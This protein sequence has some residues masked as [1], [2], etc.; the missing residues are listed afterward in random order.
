M[1]YAIYVYATILSM[2]SLFAWL[3][4]S[5]TRAFRRG[6]TQI[7]REA[8]WLHGFLVLL[9]L[10]ILVQLTFLF[11]SGMQA[12]LSLLRQST[13]LRLTIQPGATDASVQGMIQ[14]LQQQSYIDTVLFITKEQALERQRKRDPELIE[15]LG[16]FGLQNPFPDTLGIRLKS[17]DA[18]PALK[19][20][21]RKPVYTAVVDPAF[22]SEATNQEQ[23]LERITEAVSGSR[24]LLLFI[25]GVMSLVLF[26][27]IV[28]LVT[29]RAG[30]RSQ[31]LFVERLM[32]GSRMHLGLPFLFEIGALLLMALLCSL[33]FITLLALLLPVVIPVL[34]SGGLFASWGEALGATF[35]SSL[36]LMIGV[37]LLL[38]ALLATVGTFLA[39]RI[40]TTEAPTP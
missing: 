4:S 19:E 24:I 10:L 39:L 11:G 27:T 30:S 16:T 36:P 8:G 26:S 35:F 33:V 6:L 1:K 15:F 2:P 13:D 29:R 3:P 21:L 20:L 25:A 14:E 38:L 17:L 12:G 18:Y 22:L 23:T 5:L 40:W 7:I 37:E 32:G 31:D 34:R 28:E 9:G